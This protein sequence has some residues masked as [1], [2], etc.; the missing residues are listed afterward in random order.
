MA[1]SQVGV[2][3]QFTITGNDAST[4]AMAS[5]AELKI[6]NIL[7]SNLA[8]ASI[9][10]SATAEQISSFGGIGT[11]IYRQPFR[12][13]F[14][15]DYDVKS[16]ISRQSTGASHTT[17]NMDQH[18]TIDVMFED[19]DMTRFMEATPSIR[20]SM[21]SEWLSSGM[22]SYFLSLEAIFL[23][24]VIDYTIAYSNVR[25]DNILQIDPST[26]TSADAARKIYLDINNW[27]VKLSTK[28]T[29]T[30]MGID[31]RSFRIALS[32]ELYNAFVAWLP[33]F[34]LNEWSFE[35]LASGNLYKD[36]L[37]GV[38]M[39]QHLLL[40]H[41][42]DKGNMT[43]LN[44]DISFDFTGVHLLIYIDSAVA[45]PIGMEQSEMLKDNNL[46]NPK[47]ISKNLGSLPQIQRGDYVALGMST[48]PDPTKIKAAQSQI[49]D[50]TMTSYEKS[51]QKSDWDPE[52]VIPSAKPK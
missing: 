26:I 31:K 20:A 47:W 51:F 39:Q 14:G 46:L 11:A 32:M 36:S 10:S 52:F 18:L 43:G 40:N 1:L 35:P 25:V 34:I 24:G 4:N 27:M 22:N 23:R 7:T 6:K 9:R 21:L 45:Q 49:Y 48:I 42:Y 41:K 15:T 2:V 17:L 50:P 37:F 19:F 29:K 13:V 38:S 12:V 44:K 30:A 8:L 5:I 28:F 3:N 33:N 16:G